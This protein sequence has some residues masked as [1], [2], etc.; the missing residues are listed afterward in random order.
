MAAADLVFNTVDWHAPRV[1]FPGR[2]AEPEA[3][4]AYDAWAAAPFVAYAFGVDAEG[5][6]VALRI[7][8]FKPFFYARA[9]DDWSD[10]RF[11][12]FAAAVAEEASS[13]RPRGPRVAYAMCQK[14]D[15]WG[16]ANGE[17]RRFARFT[18]DNTS[19]FNR[20]RRA[21]DK[22]RRKPRQTPD[23]HARDVEAWL[24]TDRG[25]VRP[26]EATVEPLLRLIHDRDLRS[27]GWVRIAAGAYKPDEGE[28]TSCARN[29]TAHVRNVMPDHAIMRLAP[30]R[31][32][33]FD[34]E[35]TSAHGDFPQAVKTY[36]KLAG[37]LYMARKTATT[38]A[39]VADLVADAF[40]R[41][42]VVP[43]VPTPDAE[44]RGT[45]SRAGTARRLLD[46][47]RGAAGDKSLADFV[48][49]AA[50]LRLSTLHRDM[51]TVDD[52]VAA[53]ASIRFAPAGDDDAAERRRATLDALRAYLPRLVRK[54]GG[55]AG[56]AAAAAA[57]AAAAD[58]GSDDEGGT[59]TT[60]PNKE[61]ALYLLNGVL[62]SV[63]P[64]LEGDAIINVSTTTH[65]FGVPG[66]ESRHSIAL[67]PRGLAEV[68]DAV[69]VAARS[70]KEVL[71]A[72]AQHVAEVDPDVLCGWN[73]FGFDWEYVW[74]RAGELGVRDELA[75]AF[76][77]LGSAPATFKRVWSSSSAMGDNY[78]RYL[79]IPGRM[80]V[81]LMKLV[82]RERQLDSYKL[83]S[84]AQEFLGEAK[85]DV[86]PQDIFRMF[87]GGRPEDLRTIAEYCVQDCALVNKLIA[88][89]KTI[90]NTS[91]MAN[92]CSVPLSYIFMRGQG[93]KIYSLVVK[94]CAAQGV[95]VPTVRPCENGGC[96]A[97]PAYDHVASWADREKRRDRRCA[98][99]KL[100]GMTIVLPGDDVEG[101]GGE[102]AADGDVPA[103]AATDKYEG[104]IVLDPKPGMYLDDPIVV[105]DYNS[106]Y[107]SSMISENLCH[108]TIVL[109]EAR[110]G[111]VQ[112]ATYNTVVVDGV[113]FKFCSSIQGMMPLIL[114][115][116]LRERKNTRKRMEY[117]TLETADGR[118]HTGLPAGVKDGVETL[119]DVSS[120]ER[121]DVTLADVVKRADTYD[122]FEKA[123]LDGLQL[124]LKVTANSLYGQTGARTSA[125]H[126]KAIAACTTAVGRA[127]IIKAKA[128]VEEKFEGEVVYGDSVLPHTPLTLQVVDGHGEAIVAAL[129]AR[130]VANVS[131]CV[132]SK[133]A[134]Q[135]AQWLPHPGL[136]KAGDQKEQYVPPAD[137]PGA[138]RAWTHVGWARVRRVIRHV[139]AKAAYRV[140]VGGGG[141]V[142]VTEDHSLLRADGREVKPTELCA[143]DALLQAGAATKG[144][145]IAPPPK[146][147]L[148][149]VNVYADDDEGRVRI[150]AASHVAAQATALHYA[151]RGYAFD[152]TE[153]PLVD[154]DDAFITVAMLPPGACPPPP[155][156]VV[157]VERLD[158]LPAG[159]FVYDLETEAG[160]FAAGVGNI[161]VK[162]TDSIFIKFPMGGL[163]G[164]D[165][166]AEAIRRG[167]EV[168]RHI[169]EILKPPQKLAYEKVSTTLRYVYSALF[170][171]TT[172][173]SPNGLVI[174]VG[175][176]RRLTS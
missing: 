152:S 94:T 59:A 46:V 51:L 65:R 84:V 110:Y 42:D 7:T 154:D 81:D 128:Y 11:E 60:D 21:F 131:A 116:L 172:S 6:S 33:S 24:A 138:L 50:V 121:V 117:A 26:Y 48:G 29:Y 39:A 133:R 140:T 120:G 63:L 61:R 127:H 167:Q 111:A 92:V 90:E 19:V 141:V 98:Q 14:R 96:T 64:P 91:Q 49:A 168:E 171:N 118:R 102:G 37:D 10:K 174:R 119:L 69:A 3:K 163:K 147:A 70:E 101:D 1:T 144:A 30:L 73:I 143:G 86:S 159:C 161:I 34:I 22:P 62:T 125:I 27:C 97:R 9:P 5:A 45:L 122:A 85:H 176:N 156:R 129:A 109:D 165:A 12:T 104:A 25:H 166:L 145:R 164:R 20:A 134:I 80:S 55:G 83:D 8:G 123:V 114:E 150:V 88:K 126:M 112:G 31:I 79:A 135:R 17:T 75:V 108:S 77:R 139:T 2:A 115:T 44:V 169:G 15:M 146:N 148:N 136:L 82:Q 78:N 32:A 38:E 67:A 142:D 66:F 87:K 160:V 173:L 175:A 4:E 151:A 153:T 100:P 106:L 47:M 23:E 170:L 95:L 56:G 162:N 35:C 158:P 157:S 71:L 107:P 28:G 36:R 130:D 18:A 53:R 16:F 54:T 68:A 72:W 13:R 137:G 52:L 93:V 149:H 43:K 105:L 132:A 74:D 89:F 155:G 76:S 57:A 113:P 58:D 41:G 99:C 40:R 124:S 103:Y